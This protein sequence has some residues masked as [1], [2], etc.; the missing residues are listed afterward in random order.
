MFELM[1]K[2]VKINSWKLIVSTLIFYLI[3]SLIIFFIEPDTFE[4]LFNAFWW[5]MT[6]VTTVGYG[7]YSPVTVAGKI[8][9]LV[10]YVFGIGLI[11]IIIGKVVDSY[12]YYR[13]L[14]VEGKLKYKGN[15]HIVI[16]GWS[17]KSEKTIDELLLTPNNYKDIV[18]I[19]QLEKS[20]IEHERFYFIKGDPTDSNI[21]DKANVLST[22]SVSIFAPDYINDET[23]ADGKSL[24][25]SSAI[26]SYGIENGIDI[27]TIVEIVK[28]NHIRMFEHIKIDEFILSNEAFPFLM[29]KSISH[30]GAS[31]LYMQLLSKRYGDDLWEIKPDPSWHTYREA[32]EDLK[33]IGANLIAD[34]SDFSIIRRLNDKVPRNARLYVICDKVTYNKI[35][36][37]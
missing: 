6:T 35:K 37:K 12:S 21:L 36:N 27:Y 22:H 15:N 19:D 33:N 20:P 26:E 34:R 17:N 9:G 25:I 7:D 14:K 3:S 24:L 13:M 1:K 11:G 28:E 2:V 4:S 8:Y 10:L 23:T 30:K 16:I 29:A 5:V 31:Q 32:F 18:L